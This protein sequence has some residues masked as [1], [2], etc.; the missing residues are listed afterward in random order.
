MLRVNNEDICR[1]DGHNSCFYA[2]HYDFTMKILFLILC[3]NIHNYLLHEGMFWANTQFATPI[4][5][6]VCTDYVRM[7]GLKTRFPCCHGTSPE[8]SGQARDQTC[9][10][11][12]T[13]RVA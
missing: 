1:S 6:C 7:S 4:V 3:T 10:S 11:W 12:F 13:I 8:R 9:D 2:V 5:Y